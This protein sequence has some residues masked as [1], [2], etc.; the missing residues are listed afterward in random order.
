VAILSEALRNY[1]GA[2][3]KKNAQAGKQHQRRADQMC[4]IPKKAVQFPVLSVSIADQ[5]GNIG[6]K[7]SLM[8]KLLEK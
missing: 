4:G 2:D 1:G 3:C 7:R 8:L 5:I 6:T